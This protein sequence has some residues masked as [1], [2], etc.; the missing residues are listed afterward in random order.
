M[1]PWTQKDSNDPLCQL[2]KAFNE[3]ALENANEAYNV[4]LLEYF[5]QMETAEHY[6]NMGNLKSQ[7]HNICQMFWNTEWWNTMSWASRERTF[8]ETGASWNWKFPSWKPEQEHQFLT[9]CSKG[10]IFPAKGP[11]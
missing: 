1:S 7:T 6:K 8:R 5:Q 9:K 11:Y 3:L 2:A 4:V 10:G